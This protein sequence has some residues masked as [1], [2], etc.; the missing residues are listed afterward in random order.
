M[1]FG[2]ARGPSRLAASLAAR[3]SRSMCA[4][5]YEKVSRIATCVSKESGVLSAGAGDDNRTSTT[6]TTTTQIVETVQILSVVRHTTRC[7]DR[8]LQPNQFGI[9]K[10]SNNDHQQQ[11]RAN[12]HKRL[13]ESSCSSSSSSSKS[14]SSAGDRKRGSCDNA[15]VSERATLM[16]RPHALSPYTIAYVNAR[17]A[18]GII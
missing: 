1:R 4:F 9:N 12:K 10:S 2:L 5:V 11:Q 13:S 8:L 15:G 7:P 14:C 16:R 6:T 18:S 17:F 3:R